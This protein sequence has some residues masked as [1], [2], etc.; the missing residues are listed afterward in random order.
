MKKFSLG[1]ILL[2]GLLLVCSLGF[3]FQAASVDMH[4]KNVIEG[5][6]VGISDPE[7]GYCMGV[8]STGNASVKPKA[9]SVGVA[10]GIYGTAV[11]S[12]ACEITGY[13]LTVGTADEYAEIYDGTTRGTYATCLADPQ[14][15]TAGDVISRDFTAPITVSTGIYVYKSATTGILRV[16][17]R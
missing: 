17:Y 10:V 13:E 12:G 9:S 1:A 4:S 14:G 5:L 3:A 7:D 11:Y 8:D 15:H 16:N 6:V 2:V